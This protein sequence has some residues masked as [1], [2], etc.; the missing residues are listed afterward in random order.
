[1]PNNHRLSARWLGER[2]LPQGQWNCLSLRQRM[3]CPEY[4]RSR[5]TSGCSWVLVLGRRDPQSADRR[6]VNIAQP[7]TVQPRHHQ[8]LLVLCRHE[9]RNVI[10]LPNRACLDVELWDDDL[11]FLFWFGLCFFRLWIRLR[12]LF[13]FLHFTAANSFVDWPRESTARR[14]WGAVF[15]SPRAPSP[16]GNI[17]S[18]L[19]LT[20][21]PQVRGS[22][23]QVKVSFPV[24]SAGELLLTALLSC[25]TAV[26]FRCSGHR[27]RR[28]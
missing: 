26:Y 25:N 24:V 9:I 5:R 7:G 3:W 4:C 27:G 8:P 18:D 21:R 14:D 2:P 19:L 17:G 16:R 11:V 10:H 13:V 15:I 20:K 12:N 22:G 28:G 6:S 23:A 1:L